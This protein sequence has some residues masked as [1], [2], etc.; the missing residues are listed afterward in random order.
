MSEPVQKWELE[1]GKARRC[2]ISGLVVL[3]LPCG[4]DGRWGRFGLELPSL[5]E[6]GEKLREKCEKT[7]NRNKACCVKRP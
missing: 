7:A 4:T 1:E 5:G 3:L 6:G 2:P